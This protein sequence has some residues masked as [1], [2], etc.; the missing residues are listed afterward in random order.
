[1]HILLFNDTV[2]PALKYGGTERIMWWLGKELVKRGHK[3]SFLVK[4][5]SYCDFAEVIT[6][7]PDKSIQSQ[8]PKDIDIVHAH[9]ITKEN[10]SQP[11][12]T[13]IHGNIPYGQELPLNSVF[14]SQNH[15]ERYG[16]NIY[17]YNGL[18]FSDYGDP[19]LGIERKYLHF[20]AKAAWRLKNVRGAIDIVNRLKKQ[21]RVIG[22][23]RLNIKMGF[24]FTL[25]FN[26]HFYGMI[27]GEKKNEIL[28]HSKGLIFPVLW[29]EPFG[30]AI[31]ESLYFGCPVFGTPYGSLPE[32]VPPEVGFLSASKKELIHAIQNSDYSSE[33]CHTYAV[34]NFNSVKMAERYIALYERVLNGEQLNAIHPTLQHKQVEKFLPFYN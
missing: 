2:I 21:L 26:I 10:F 33:A 27:G 29:H 24:R 1:M 25:Y 15:A 3:V 23:Y 31:V 16:S 34:E 17:V 9:Y 6:F 8:I 18:D 32:L 20:L 13:T 28:R 12:I 11:T 30:I 14:V 7:D 5:G 4:K 22:G 19:G